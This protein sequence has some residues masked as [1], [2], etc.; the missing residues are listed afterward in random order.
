MDIYLE[1]EEPSAVV[2]AYY[3]P[4]CLEPGTALLSR[5][6]LQCPCACGLIDRLECKENCESTAL[7]EQRVRGARDAAGDML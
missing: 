3:R 4:C 2:A 1:G 6:A 5:V 7:E